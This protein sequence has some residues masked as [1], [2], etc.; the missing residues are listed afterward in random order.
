MSTVQSSEKKLRGGYYTPAAVA[1]WLAKWAIRSSSDRV[2]EPSC[3]DGVFLE[4]ASSALDSLR[5]R[6][7]K[8]QRQIVGIEL[9]PDEASAAKQRAVATSEVISGD[10]FAWLE[11]HGS[12]E[13]FDAVIG[14]PPFIRYQNFPEPARTLA[15]DFMQS[16]G[17]RPNRLTNIWVPFVVAGISLLKEDGRLAMVVPA[18]LLQVTYAGQLRQYL[19]DSFKRI[20]IYAC[21]EMFFPN[22]EQEVVL[23]LAEGKLGNAD[24]RNKCDISLV[25]TASVAQLLRR[26]A[27]SQTRK[28]RPKFLQHE[29]EK[30]LKYFLDAEEIDFMRALREHTAIGPLSAHCTVDVGVVTGKNDFFVLDQQQLTEYEAHDYVVPLVG[31]SAQLAGTLLKPGEFRR[32]A[33]DG[34]RVWLLHLTGHAPAGFTRGLRQW[35]AAGEADGVHRGYKCSIRTPW[36]QVPSVWEP[37]CFIFRQIYDFPRVV[38]NKAKATSTDTIHR[39][40][41]ASNPERIASNIYT[42]LTAASAEIEGRSYGGGVLELEPTEAERVLVPRTLNGAMPIAEAD[43]LVRAGRLDQVL[44]HNDNVVLRESLGLSK[45]ECAMLK[46]IWVKMRDRRKSRRRA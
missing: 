34:K 15:M 5:K 1:K 19:S 39:V 43:Q 42:H 33:D 46:R 3:G 32:M 36:Y 16:Q 35:I 23:L 28:A 10:F 44:E 21:N 30:W 29:S 31:R 45:G 4:C 17:L 13:R 7:S 41:C 38:V 18:E 20:T 2:L 9:I 11:Q 8:L 37:D 14:N 12:G 22:A 40:R 25:E 27:R 24:P 6:G 26:N